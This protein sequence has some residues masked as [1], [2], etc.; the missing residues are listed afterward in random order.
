MSTASPRALFP[1]PGQQMPLGLGRRGQRSAGTGPQGT[2]WRWP[3]LHAAPSA[4]PLS[5]YHSGLTRPAFA[6]LFR[7]G[8]I[9]PQATSILAQLSHA[10][11]EGR[12]ACLEQS[13][14]EVPHFVATISWNL[15]TRVCGQDP[16]AHLQWTEMGGWEDE[17]L[18][19]LEPGA[20]RPPSS[21]TLARRST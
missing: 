16:G 9:I 17:S 5:G 21:N 18:G 2:S 7:L 11:K 15:E 14:L 3:A 13:F 4:R 12:A 19:H 20:P 8:L 10:L 6:N 1:R